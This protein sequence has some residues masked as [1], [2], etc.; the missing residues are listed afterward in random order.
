MRRRALLCGLAGVGRTECSLRDLAAAK[1]IRFGSEMLCR[2]LADAAYADLVRCQCGIIVPGLEAKWDHVEPTEGDF[3]FAPLDRLAAFAGDAG[4]Q[5]RLHTI[6]WGLAMPPWLVAALHEGRGETVLRRHIAAVVG[7][8]RGRASAWDV[9][10]EAS[11]PRWRR[12]PEGLTLTPWRTA[13]GPHYVERAFRLAA[14]ADD[15]A[16]LFLNDDDLEYATPDAEAKRATYLRLLGTWLRRGVPIGGFGLQAHLKPERPLAVDAYRR[17]LAELA[18]MG[19][20]LHVTELDVH[21]AALPGDP[22]ARDRAVADCCRRYLD[23]AL[24]E[25][26][27][28]AVLTWG[29][30]DRYTYLN[31]DPAVRRPDGQ[32][33][34]GLPY[35]ADLRAKPMRQALIEAFAHAPRRTAGPG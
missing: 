8:Y 15:R 23:I 21:D 19:L 1:G 11:D 14:E 3:R 33:A 26:A 12:G 20:V 2:E 17:F 16:V 32:P 6:V 29:L 28:K 22:A 31:T 18:G 35:D 5:L 9:V 4:L 27:V 10:N 13:L 25:P 34:R 24:D 7:R 30:S